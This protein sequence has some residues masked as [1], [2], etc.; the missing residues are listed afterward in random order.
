MASARTSD[1]H[2]IPIQATRS[3]SALTTLSLPQPETCLRLVVSHL[4]LFPAHPDRFDRRLGDTQIGLPVAAAYPDAANTLAVNQHGHPA[5]H[6]GPTLGTCSKRK[7]DRMAHVEILAG[8]ALCRG[9]APIRCGTHR[10]R[11]GGMH[12][13][14]PAAVHPLEQ[15]HMSAG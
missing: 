12:G 7:A 15:D 11:G 9:R 14:E 1:H 8:C 5:L 4:L 2:P 6:R 13:M 10:F 3:G